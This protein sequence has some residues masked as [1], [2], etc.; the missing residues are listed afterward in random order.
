MVREHVPGVEPDQKAAVE[1]IRN[2]P[3]PALQRD[4]K[5]TE[6]YV[7]RGLR[8]DRRPDDECRCDRHFQMPRPRIEREERQCRYQQT[9]QDRAARNRH[10][11]RGQARGNREPDNGAHRGRGEAAP[12]GQH[13]QETNQRGEKI[14]A[15]LRVP[16][17][18]SGP[19][20]LD[21]CV[22]DR[23][24]IQARAAQAQVDVPY[25]VDQHAEGHDDRRE[26]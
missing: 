20:D 23:Q 2:L 19:V 18:P 26:R 17:E 25:P 5:Q 8:D 11:Q 4:R 3:D 13:E 7:E 14:A 1:R 15:R 10:Q 21:A 9:R 22:V 16:E 12:H 24:Q 6:P